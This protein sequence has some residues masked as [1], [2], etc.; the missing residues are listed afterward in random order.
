MTKISLLGRLSL[1][2]TTII[3]MSC[4][5][6]FNTIGSDIVGEN[7]FDLN[8]ESFEVEAYD[9]VA[10]PVQSNNLMLS[11]QSINSLGIY[12]DE[13]FGTRSSKF[14]TQVALTDDAPVIGANP[15]IDSVW[16]YVP[17][18]STQ[19]GTNSDGSR[20]YELDSVFTGGQAKFRLKIYENGYYL[21]DY[22]TN[23]N[24]GIEAQR[25]YSN[26]VGKVTPY[27]LGADANNEPATNGA[28]LNNSTDPAENTG[29]YFSPKEKIIYKTNGAGLYVDSEGVVLP[30]ADQSNLSKRVIKE[31]F[32]PGM[33]INLNKGY[34]T[35]RILEASSDK[36]FNN[37]AFREY[38]RGLFFDVEA[39]DANQWAM[40]M[41]DFSK[42]YI[43]IRYK[44][45]GVDDGNP[46]T[47]VARVRK[48]MTLSLSGNTINF[49]AGG[50]DTPDD[51]SRL[52]LRGGG[53][54]TSVAYIKLFGNDGPDDGDVPDM[55]EEIRAKG[56]MINEA[57]LVFYIDQQKMGQS[58]M[59]EPRR[60]YLYDA[61]N[62]KPI[63]DY[64]ADPTTNASNPK[65]NKRGYG[66]IMEE[67]ASGKGLKYKI[68][69]TDYMRSCI[70]NDSTNF[71]LGVVITENINDYANAYLAPTA[72]NVTPKRVVPVGTVVSPLGTVLHSPTSEDFEKRLKLEI[73]YT[74]PD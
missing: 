57:N 20:F 69:I 24:G 10:G 66:G 30:A 52:Y 54:K 68:R 60:I 35:N 61:K 19:K 7:H 36:L 41:L 42:G 27:L 74:K 71:K 4:D 45:D 49:F 39:I 32:A 51:P 23:E 72:P 18:F 28:Y 31:R 6:E 22:A 3:F 21:N 15:A 43:N 25:H 14:V 38:F 33:W 34:M 53:D 63:A 48:T 58:G 29:F 8:K 46:E 59:N 55:L 62:K 37:N 56:W 65:Y 16:V 11:N 26:E 64:L 9:S 47:P 12:K 40:A 50:N 1:L 13:V 70:E 2:M 17:Y 5:K 67:D 73:Y 44:V